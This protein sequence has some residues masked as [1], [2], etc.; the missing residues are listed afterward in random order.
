MSSS[1][2]P[3]LLFLQDSHKSSHKGQSGRV[4]VIGGSAEYTGAPYF[5]GM[6][7]MRTGADLAH[8]FC[9]AS[10]ASVI[11]SY[12]PDVIVHPYLT[13][14]D[15]DPWLERMHSIVIGP[16][17]G[18]NENLVQELRG[19]LSKAI[20]LQLNIVIDADGLF[21]FSRYKDILEQEKGKAIVVLT[22]NVMEFSRLSGGQKPTGNWP[23][24]FAEELGV[25]LVVK[26][27]EDVITDGEVTK[28][29]S[30][31]GSRKRCG[32]QGDLL[33]GALATFLHAM[34]SASPIVAAVES[35]KLV[36]RAAVL[37]D[38][39]RGWSL[40]ASDVLQEIPIALEEL[41]TELSYGG[42]QKK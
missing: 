23:Q 37:A 14:E 30:S 24:Q 10:A 18:R 4:A 36:R 8:I 13:S 16:G 21:F 25:I 26:G 19:I 7:A 5:S 34:G 28:K 40:V 11:K 22:P 17:L 27:P 42:G 35:C 32:G 29:V 38:R 39:K 41:V 31:P 20:N 3:S 6:T 33:T 9:D 12:S 15:V 1:S 2:L